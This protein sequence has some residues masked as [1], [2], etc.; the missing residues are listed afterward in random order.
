MEERLSTVLELAGLPLRPEEHVDGASLAPALEG[1]PMEERPLFWHYPHYG[2]QG[3]DPSSIIRVGDWKLIRY[4][5]DRPDELYRLSEDPAERADVAANFPEHARRLRARLDE[6]LAEVGAALPTP[7][8]KFDAA[9]FEAELRDWVEKRQPALEARAAA[10]L[11][12]GWSPNPTWWGSE[13]AS[14]P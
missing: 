9:A 3:G 6:W 11:D 13:P 4:Y 1:R 7:N 2:N 14:R 10:I 8:P 5:E 12:P